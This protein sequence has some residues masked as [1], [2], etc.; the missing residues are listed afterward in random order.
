MPGC[1]SKS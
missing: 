1:W